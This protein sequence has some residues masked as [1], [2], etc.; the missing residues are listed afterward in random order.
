MKPPAP[1]EEDVYHFDD[2][3][4]AELSIGQL[5]GSL[6]EAIEELE[7]DEVLMGTLGEHTGRSFVEAKCTEWDE[8]R[9]QVTEWELERYLETL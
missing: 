2:A 6:K 5:P 8:Y 1:V 9:I 7:G 3:K 4:L